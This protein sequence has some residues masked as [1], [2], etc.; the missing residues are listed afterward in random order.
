MT[1]A[2]EVQNSKFDASRPFAVVATFRS[3]RKIVGRY[4]TEEQ[5]N[6]RARDLNREHVNG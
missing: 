1:N 5:A 2:Y 6:R 4:A 3:F